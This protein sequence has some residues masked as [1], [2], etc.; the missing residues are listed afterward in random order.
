MIGLR[1]LGR[2]AGDEIALELPKAAFLNGG[3]GI[4]H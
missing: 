3:A 1:F 4:L 2:V